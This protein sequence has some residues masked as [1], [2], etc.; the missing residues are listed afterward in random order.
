MHGWDLARALRRKWD[1]PAADAI[2]T[3]RGL[4]EVMPHFV[5]QQAAAEFSGTFQVELRGGPTMSMTF[6]RG[7]L[8]IREGRADRADCRIS[9]D[10]APFILISYGRLPLWQPAITGKMIAYGR[11]PWRSLKMTSLMRQP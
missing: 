10:P 4:C 6:D 7:V 1:I 8:T 11:K 5:D 2:V 3:L 9:A